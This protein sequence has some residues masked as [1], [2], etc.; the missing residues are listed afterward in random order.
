MVVA[1]FSGLGSYFTF[2]NLK[3]QRMNWAA[4]VDAHPILAPS[5][6]ILV[7]LLSVALSLPGATILSLLGGFLF[8]IPLSTIYVVIGATFGA[9]VIF[10]AAKTALQDILR[11]KASTYL[12]KLEAGFNQNAASYLLF[13]RF[14]P[15]FPF[16]LINI[17]PAF[18]NVKWR[19]F[20]WTTFVGIIPGA[21][22]YTQAGSGIGQILDNGETFSLSNVFNIQMRIALIALA[23]FSLVPIL[24]KKF[25]QKRKGD[26][27]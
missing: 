24:I 5:L 4:K 23:I 17:A 6:F 21:Y 27:R 1:Y 11:K 9:L 25:M 18:F 20:V 2:D 3:A 13:L 26:D 22:V 16:W 19:T 10:L 15:L 14:I 8:G 7:Y 12:G